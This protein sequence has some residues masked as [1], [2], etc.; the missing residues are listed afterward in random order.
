M[1]KDTLVIVVCSILGLFVVA[2]LSGV[3][4]LVVQVYEMHPKVTETA[5]RVDRIVEVLPEV[6][7]Q[8]AEEELQKRVQ[9]AFIARDAVET[10]AGQWV[11][12]VDID[13]YRS[14][15][16]QVF[17]IALK[18]PDDQSAAYLLTG[19]ASRIGAE[20]ISF[21]EYS[22][23]AA[24]I[25]KPQLYNTD[26]DLAA[27]FAITRASKEY[28][29]RIQ[30]LFGKPVK[31]EEILKGMLRVEQLMAELIRK[32]QSGSPSPSKSSSP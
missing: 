19:L 14:G 3:G 28:P 21:V 1:K 20:K 11:K 32:K 6:R 29:Q 10:A 25:G 5:Y 7:R 31:Q 18:G 22:A 27:S 30:E 8:V 17:E 23:I 2:L 12:T 9:L 26:I 24:R 16:R 15:K 4:W 13:D